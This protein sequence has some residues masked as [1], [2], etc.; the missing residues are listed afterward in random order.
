MKLI[1]LTGGEFAMVDDADYDHLSQWKWKAKEDKGNL[2]AC[3]RFKTDSG[4]SKSILMHRE[5]LKAPPGAII[6]RKDGNGLNNQ[7]EN[8]RLCSYEQNAMNRKKRRGCSS[9]F[10]GVHYDPRRNK[11]RVQIVANGRKIRLNSFSSE[12][13]A[14]AVYDR[15]AR[16]LFGDFSRV[17]SPPQVA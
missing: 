5:I 11:W 4:K 16:E 8:I 13:E 3:R 12:A 7:R 6:D 15:M 17:N 9:K 1:P 14:A 2:Y 10:K